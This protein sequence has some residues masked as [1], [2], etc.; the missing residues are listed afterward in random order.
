MQVRPSNVAVGV[1]ALQANTT[2]TSSTA[3][4][5]NA[6]TA[7]TTGTLNIGIGAGAGDT[8]TTGSNNTVIGD[9]AGSAALA[10]TL[11][12]GTG[13]TRRIQHDANGFSINGDSVRVETSKT[14]A[15]AN[16]TGIQGQICWDSDYVYVCTATNTWKRAAIA[17]WP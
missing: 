7:Q 9:L 6:L 3:V 14:P 17:T 13:T 10:N 12:I 16:A 2:G 1:T 15:A 4:G 8:I 11:L 5:Y